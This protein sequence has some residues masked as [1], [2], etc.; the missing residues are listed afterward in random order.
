MGHVNSDSRVDAAKEGA[1]NPADSP[2]T[3][4]CAKLARLL[5]G[6]LSGEGRCG[7]RR[8]WADRRYRRSGLPVGR[9]RKCQLCLL[10]GSGWE[11][12]WCSPSS[13]REPRKQGNRPK[14]KETDEKQSSALEK[15]G[16]D[17][18]SNLQ[19]LQTL[20]S[21]GGVPWHFESGDF[22]AAGAARDEPSLRSAAET[23]NRELTLHMRP[24]ASV[25]TVDAS[26]SNRQQ[27]LDENGAKTIPFPELKDPKLIKPSQGR[28][29]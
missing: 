22:A 9:R 8:E 1:R 23:T 25:R 18:K 20:P 17:I 19:G 7:T 3:N 12:A 27:I 14:E 11:R 26:G 15:S 5:G 21:I 10:A 6:G 24:A 4:E 28:H 2:I 13:R 16:S 29:R